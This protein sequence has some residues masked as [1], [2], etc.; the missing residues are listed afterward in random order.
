MSAT[1]AD[2]GEV[3]FKSSFPYHWLRAAWYHYLTILDVDYQ[4]GFMC[5]NCG[6]QPT[7]VV[8]DATSLAF[9][10]QLL[11]SEEVLPQCH[12]TDEQPLLHGRYKQKYSLYCW[13]VTVLGLLCKN[14][15]YSSIHERV[16]IDDNKCRQFLKTYAATATNNDVL[17]RYLS[18]DV[19]DLVTCLTEHCPVL[20]DLIVHM[21]KPVPCP[22]V[23][24]SLLSDLS[25][26]SP[27]CAL[28]TPI[29][30]VISLVCELCN[31]L[32]VKKFPEK[33]KQTMYLSCT[34]YFASLDQILRH[35]LQSIDR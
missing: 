20:A 28:L 30:Q 2:S 4:S 22:S 31:G 16:F 17:A 24:S 15:H 14:H 9:R 3:N 23:C 8:C 27:V 32:E 6:E 21:E 1:H 25:T 5:P 26:T 11:P 7:S 35:C 18:S 33:W 10:R 19:D 13:I 29:P 34:T 12:D